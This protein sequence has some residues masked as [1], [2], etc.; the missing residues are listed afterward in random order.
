MLKN[1]SL[2]QKGFTIVELLIV[3]VVIG[4]LAAL[5]MNTFSGIQDKARIVSAQNDLKILEKSILLGRETT[6]KTLKEITYNGWTWYQCDGVADRKNLPKTH[7]CW[8]DYYSALDK[9]G[10]AANT[11][12]DELKKGDPWGQPYAIDENEGDFAVDPCQADEIASG[13]KDLSNPLPP[14]GDDIYVAVRLL[15][16]GCS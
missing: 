16:T 15:T 5:V 6:G 9:I 11:N 12:L 13:G 14:S 1:T 4:I 8:T 2:I 7:G 10:N 3:I